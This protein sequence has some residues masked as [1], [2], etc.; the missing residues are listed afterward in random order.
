MNAA[1]LAH[2]ARHTGAARLHT[3]RG[4]GAWLTVARLTLAQPGSRFLLARALSQQGLVKTNPAKIWAKSQCTLNWAPEPS[5]PSLKTSGS[6]VH[7]LLLLASPPAEVTID[8]CITAILK[9]MT[10]VSIVGATC[11]FPMLLLLTLWFL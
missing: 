3:S 6:S 5:F 8:S 2:G 10:M 11:F 1:S 4:A 7:S 9:K